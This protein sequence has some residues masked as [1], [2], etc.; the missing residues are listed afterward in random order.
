MANERVINI[1]LMLLSLALSAML[2]NL[3]YILRPEVRLLEEAIYSES[4]LQGLSFSL[5]TC[6]ALSFLVA[7][8]ALLGVFWRQK[9]L[10]LSLLVIILLFLL[11][12]FSLWSFSAFF[13][14][15]C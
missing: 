1:G 10:R 14:A 2:Y 13:Y 8:L 6:A 11:V 3:G 4:G 9:A 7:V 15:V 12:A 5:I